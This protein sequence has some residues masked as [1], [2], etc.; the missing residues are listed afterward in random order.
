MAEQRLTRRQALELGAA[1]V[2]GVTL[3][4]CGGRRGEMPGET[5]LTFEWNVVASGNEGP[6]PRSRH[7]LVNDRAAKATILFG[8]IIWDD[9]ES[10]HSDTW[11]LQSGRWSQ[12][13]GL[14]SPPARHR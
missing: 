2:A 7:C 10:L 14:E 6:G 4:G 12:V 3:P 9:Q 11:E 13:K 8:G 5:T 1:L